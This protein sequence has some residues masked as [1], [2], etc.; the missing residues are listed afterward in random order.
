MELRCNSDVLQCGW[1]FISGF[2]LMR[3]VKH[4]AWHAI[5][6]IFG[7]SVG[8][9]CQGLESTTAESVHSLNQMIKLICTPQSHCNG[10]EPGHEQWEGVL[11]CL[12]RWW[13]IYIRMKYKCYPN[14]DHY[15][16]FLILFPHV[17]KKFLKFIRRIWAV[18]TVLGQECGKSG[19][20]CSGIQIKQVSLSG[21][22][23]KQ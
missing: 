13:L 15:F 18:G 7:K 2:C 14:I 21:L 19:V 23:R 6:E 3:C 12:Q 4:Y 8:R 16:I 9:Y 17:P 22:M 10:H 20:K 11:L 5:E 1:I